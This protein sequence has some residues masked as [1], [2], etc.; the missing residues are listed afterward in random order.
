MH[1]KGL[2]S[3]LFCFLALCSC[4]SNTTR[5]PSPIFTYNTSFY[6]EDSEAMT[7]YYNNHEDFIGHYMTARQD[8]DTLMVKT[9]FSVNGCGRAI[10]QVFTEADTLYLD[11]KETSGTLCASTRFDW[12]TFKI[13]NPSRKKYLLKSGR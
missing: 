1:G 11:R 4:D 12:Y 3:F 7:P 8:G 13:H 2:F 10:G 9:L 6:A 5:M